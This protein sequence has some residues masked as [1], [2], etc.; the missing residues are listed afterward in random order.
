MAP[1]T[2]AG[3]SRL[4]KLLTALASPRTAV[5]NRGWRA[6]S[7]AGTSWMIRADPSPS[8]AAPISVS[9]RTED[10]S[11]SAPAIWPVM[12]VTSPIR[13]PTRRTNGSAE[14]SGDDQRDREKAWV[15]GDLGP[16][17]A[18]LRPAAGRA[19]RRCR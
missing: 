8:S 13:W 4:A 10:A 19:P 2:A 9:T 7:A 14:Q 12:A 15:E 3:A 17:D 18:E 6:P 16:A 11:S 5:V 1:A